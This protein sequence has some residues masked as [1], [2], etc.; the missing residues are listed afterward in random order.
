MLARETHPGV[1]PCPRGRR[2]LN[3]GT[4]SPRSHRLGTAPWHSPPGGTRGRAPGLG[5]LGGGFLGPPPPPRS[6]L[7]APAP[8]GSDGSGRDREHRPLRAPR[9]PRDPPPC[10]AL[11]PPAR[12]TGEWPPGRSCRPPRGAPS[13][14]R[15]QITPLRAADPPSPPP[16]G[17]M[18]S[19]CL[20]NSPHPGPFQSV[21]VSPTLVLPP[22]PS[23]SLALPHPPCQRRSPPW[24]W[25]P[26]H[27]PHP[28]LPC[29][30][31]PP[32]Q[33]GLSHLPDPIA[34]PATS[35]QPPQASSPRTLPAWTPP[36]ANI[37]VPAA[38]SPCLQGLL[39]PSAPFPF[40]S[41]LS[42]YYLS[43]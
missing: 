22:G 10:R 32:T 41:S 36:R 12:P 17:V 11:R 29:L 42:W 23:Q 16:R 33:G 4:G 27:R 2:S 38:A 15:L 37:S 25:S 9:I 21:T 6:L 14:A 43:L 20:P 1:A 26:G 34:C 28:S 3:P 39:S 8:P 13:L 35:V 31:P 7:P 24:G 19:P 5:R 40:L 18:V 30:A